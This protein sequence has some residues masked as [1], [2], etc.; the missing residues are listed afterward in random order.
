MDDEITVAILLCILVSLVN[1]AT[2]IYLSDTNE[3]INID[4]LDN[5]CKILLNNT[6]AE[7][8]EEFGIQDKFTCILNNEIM[9][10]DNK[11]DK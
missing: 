1:F 10:I 7:Y 9:V 6:E 11:K 3:S 4:A 8:Y 5:T 2:N